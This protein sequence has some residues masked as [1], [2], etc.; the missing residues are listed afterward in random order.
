MRFVAPSALPSRRVHF[1]EPDP[2][3]ACGQ[4]RHC[5]PTCR[6]KATRQRA[7]T[8]SDHVAAHC[9]TADE[10]VVVMGG[11]AVREATVH[12]WTAIGLRR[13]GRPAC[14]H[15]DKRG[16]VGSPCNRVLTGTEV[17]SVAR[18]HDGGHRY[19]TA[20]G[21]SR[22]L[23]AAGPGRSPEGTSLP[24]CLPI[25]F[26]GRTK[27]G[28]PSVVRQ[29]L[30]SPFRAEARNE[31][32]RR[33]VLTARGSLPKRRT[34]VHVPNGPGSSSRASKLASLRLRRFSR[35]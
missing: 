19:P 24:C 8:P 2:E 33:P 9:P 14:G 28:R 30:S 21:S 26:R 18:S 34:V 15:P 12:G 10:S 32:L 11:S 17:P 1:P 27:D 7:D 20:S 5:P 23:P 16:I 13:V 31:R 3:P 35:P 29:L 25:P 6:P 22:G 4:S